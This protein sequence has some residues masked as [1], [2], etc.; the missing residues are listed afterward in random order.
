MLVYIAS[1]VVL[2]AWSTIRSIHEAR[3][4]LSYLQ[5]AG[6]AWIAYL[7]MAAAVSRRAM[8]RRRFR[9][10]ADRQTGRTKNG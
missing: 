2:G 5:S 1:A 8:A 10:S 3:L 6:P 4:W 9:R 7:R